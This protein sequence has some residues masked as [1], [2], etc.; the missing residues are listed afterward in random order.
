MT[1]YIDKSVKVRK[2]RIGQNE[3]KG[4]ES[5]AARFGMSPHKF[6]ILVVENE[7]EAMAGRLLE[8]VQNKSICDDD[9]CSEFPNE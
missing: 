6:A 7:Y 2:L 1:K 8:A 4:L 9:F 5:W 3:W